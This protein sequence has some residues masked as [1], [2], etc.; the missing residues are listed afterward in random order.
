MSDI[1]DDHKNGG[2]ITDHLYLQDHQ[3][4]A[5]VKKLNEYKIPHLIR[6]SK[7]LDDTGFV[8][9]TAATKLNRPDFVIQIPNN[10]HFQVDELLEE[11]PELLHVSKDVRELFLSS[12]MDENGWIEILIYPEEWEEG[13]QEIAQKLLTQKG[14][15]P[16]LLELAEQQKF[17]DITRSKR[18]EK[19]GLSFVQMVFIIVLLIFTILGV[20]SES[21]FLF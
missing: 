20:L 11:H 9:L 19:A 10:L 21:S 5:V 7:N 2:K 16:T 15:Q 3:V 8:P 12:S 1:L 6:P 17:L 13:D 18:K 14:I 4:D